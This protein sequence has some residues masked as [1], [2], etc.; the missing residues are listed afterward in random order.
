MGKP[1]NQEFRDIFNTAASEY[2]ASI[3][4][5]ALS[6]RISFIT[7]H[8]HGTCLEVGAGTGEITRALS[9][10]HEVTATDLSPKM[11]EEIRKKLHI[12]T[13]VCDAQE[14]PFPDASF[15]TVVCGEAIYYLDEPERF[16]AEAYR[17]LR[18]G[19]TLLI[20]FASSMTTLYDRIRTLLRVLGFGSMYF[21]DRMH[22]YPSVA[23][24]RRLIRDNGFLVAEEKRLII[25]PAG[26]FDTLNRILEKT[27][28]KYVAAFAA[29]KATKV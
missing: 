2:D 9:K 25:I 29:L 24:V 7:E 26:S 22:T 19:G 1:S 10:I 28:L 4:P 21:D 15:D 8:A 13:V 6:R 16:I 3:N 17:V 12:P 5:Y 18:P 27:P 14:L 20:T 23:H 11:V